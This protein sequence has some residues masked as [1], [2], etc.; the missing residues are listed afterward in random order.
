[1]ATSFQEQSPASSNPVEELW[2]P[3]SEADSALIRQQLDRLLADPAFA[4]SKRYPRLLRHIVEEALQGRGSQLKERTLGI[5][6]FG[7]E[8]SYDTNQDPVVRTSAA[9]VRQRIA[10]YYREPG[11][12]AEIRIELV[13][14]S[15]VPQFRHA[16][17]P[18][19]DLPIPEAPEAGVPAENGS[20]KVGVLP[21]LP[22]PAIAQPHRSRKPVVAAAIVVL[23][24]VAVVARTRWA[25]PDPVAEFWGPVWDPHNPIVIC[26]PGKFPAEGNAAQ[27]PMSIRNSLRSNSIAWPDATTFF[28]LGSFI[29]SHGQAIHV[30]RAGDSALSDLRTGPTVLVG[31]FNNSWLMRL[32]ERLRFTYRNN[33][34]DD[35]WGTEGWIQDAQH[36]EKRDWSVRWDA[37]YSTFLE[38]Y[39]IISR[40]WDSETERVV[41][42]ASGIASYGTI[43]AG[44]FLTNPKYLA[45]IAQQAPAGWERKSIQVVFSTRV[46]NGNAGPPRI[47]AIHV[48]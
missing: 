4:S 12:E 26:V 20:D 14:G 35:G 37:P 41:V 22:V 11:H 46:F 34:T 33:R 8:P 42:T 39:G 1:M 21:P 29:Q 6:V 47:V 9:Q 38:D 19:K 28:A 18:V 7:R 15:Y 32:N 48:W 43:A 3:S 23:I 10:Q 40:V 45:M 25:A 27:Q 16:G 31:G 2:I 24:G 44:E 36:P 13:S 30:R 17:S 5:E